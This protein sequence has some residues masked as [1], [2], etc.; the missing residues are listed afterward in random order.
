MNEQDLERL[1]WYRVSPAGWW[2]APDWQAGDEALTTEE[3]IGRL[4]RG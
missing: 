2:L 4:S 3:A 1:G